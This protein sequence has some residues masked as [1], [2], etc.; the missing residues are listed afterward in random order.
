MQFHVH[1]SCEC[2]LIITYH[3]YIHLNPWPLLNEHLKLISNGLKQEITKCRLISP[4]VQLMH[5]YIHVSSLGAIS[6]A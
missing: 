1:V 2:D 5:P 6:G 4:L 3:C